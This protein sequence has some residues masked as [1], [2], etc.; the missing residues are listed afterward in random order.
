M[1][2]S[3]HWTA[4][5]LRLTLTV[6]A[7]GLLGAD[8]SRNGHPAGLRTV[9]LVT[10][11]ASVAM[12]QM[13]LLL[14][15]SGKNLSSFAVMDVMRL[16]LG[17]LTG[18]GFIGAGAIVRR[19]DLV[20]GITTAATLWFATVVGLCLGGGQIVLGCVSALI[21]YGVLTALRG[22][23]TIIERYQPAT[24]ILVTGEEGPT[25]DEL[26][27]R[28]EAAR[29]RI[30]SLSVEHSPVDHRRSLRCHVRW[31]SLGGPAHP[32]AILDELERLPG[33]IRLVWRATGTRST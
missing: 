9:L 32:P 19:G 1:H 13:D 2:P 28:L 10:L 5:A 23:E 6:L 24:L 22:L 15:T 29:M 14:P 12:I 16:P 3:L 8:R 21:G 7:G 31:P 18:V 33:L 20:L 26:R 30:R 25:L 27:T 17:I 4:I 11:A